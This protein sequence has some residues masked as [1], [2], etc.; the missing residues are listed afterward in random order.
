MNN[1]ITTEDD[2]P[3]YAVLKF[4]HVAW[5]VIHH[6]QINRITRDSFDRKMILMIVLLNEVVTE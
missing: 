6:K 4:S 5:P 3:L 1:I 2:S